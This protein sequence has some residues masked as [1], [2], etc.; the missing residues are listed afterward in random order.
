[1]DRGYVARSS[2]IEDVTPGEGDQF[3]HGVAAADGASVI[4]EDVTVRRCSAVGLVFDGARVRDGDE[5][6][7]RE[8]AAHSPGR[9][10]ADPS[11]RPA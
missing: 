9:P 8:G 10:E 5:A 4:L 1:M 3:G 6:R 11:G 2:R 7:D